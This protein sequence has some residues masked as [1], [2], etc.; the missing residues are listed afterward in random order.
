MCGIYG[1]AGFSED[2]L[3]EKMGRVLRHRGP[4]GEGRHVVR[5]G[6]AFSMGMRRLSIIDL[7]GGWQ[8]LYN[9]DSSVAVI[10]NG[11]IY[12]Y[13][14]LREELRGRG[15][16]F[17]TQSDTEVLAHG[18]EQWGIDGLLQ[19]LNGMFA[20]CIYDAARREFF[21]ARDRCGQ[22]PLYYW[23]Q[24]GRFIFAS[25]AKAILQ[26][27][28]VEARANT[29]AI[30]SY[31][32][33][34]NVPE[35]QTLFA[36]IWKL[37]AS[38][39]LRHR[40]DGNVE[41]HRYWEIQLLPAGSNAFK[42]DVE[43][44]E[45]F[46]SLFYDA[47]RLCMRSDVPVGAYLSAGV[48]SSLTVAA[49]TK[50][51]SAINT[52]SIGF[53]A[54]TDETPAAAET[55]KFLGTHHH[56]ILCRAEDFNLLPRIVWHMDRPVGDALIIAFYK[57][58]EGA[59]RDLKVI[60]GGEGADEAFAGYSFQKLICLVEKYQR[61]MPGLLHHG[62]MLPGLRATPW[63]LLDLFFTFPA[64]LGTKGKQRLVAF[65]KH[66]GGRDLNEN[67]NALRTLWALDE[68]RDLYAD[69]FKSL[70]TDAWMNK[71]PAKDR[72]GMF[73][74][75][76]LK[77]QYDEWLQDWALIRQDKNTMA[78]SLEYRLPFLDH[79]LIEFAFTLP[80]HLKIHRGTDKFIERR[81]ADKLFPRRIARR[82]KLPFY[83]PVEF[84]FEHP[85]F[86]ALVA[87]TLSESQLKKR[88]YFDPKKVA[89]LID[90][91]NRTREFV[92]CKQVMSLVIL[93]LWHRVFIDRA[94]DFAA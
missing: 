10:Q 4:D 46:E 33:L 94:Y 19:R 25:E 49:M 83:L 38:R 86:K 81:L 39:Y 54:R 34:R 72:D 45:A 44:F 87:D 61:R 71:E 91:M 64:D 27:A 20:L 40:A 74:D 48:D 56:E 16:V 75:R 57:L 79:R 7:E 93:E 9:E 84:F 41:I 80:P 55:A 15:H 12:N 73:L 37:P 1:F 3:L 63:K 35:P 17:T 77:L 59:A 22:K 47:V 68:R 13:V 51:S 21:L 26:S 65:L 69:E 28:H 82:P 30:D 23:N 2:G 70:A 24:G 6:P 58:A 53:G 52:Y 67:Y 36:G 60:L 14:E 8:P 88:G 90:S 66:F 78:H 89:D 76:L 50:F 43:Y 5:E 18:Y 62:L 32:T 42:K 11:E 29:R 85:E 92:Y 31:L